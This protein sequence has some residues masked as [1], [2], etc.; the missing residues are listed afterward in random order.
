MRL[1]AIDPGDV[2]SA[3]VVYDTL[4]HEILDKKIADNNKVLS[5]LQNNRYHIDYLVIEMIQSYGMPVGDT[6]FETCVWIG[7]FMQAWNTD[8]RCDRLSRK[9]IVNKL[10]GSARAKDANVRLALLQRF[11]ATGGG[12][13][14]Q[15]G[16]K[17]KPGPLYGVK[18]DI[19]AA[20]AVAVIW[21]EEHK[22]P[23]LSIFN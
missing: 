21:A 23:A 2:Q 17:A 13:T 12:S 11:T 22:T 1:V 9:E 7:K 6:V 19:W 10:C 8:H 16:T 3:F 4:K 20:L 14:P 5:F 15:V 18:K